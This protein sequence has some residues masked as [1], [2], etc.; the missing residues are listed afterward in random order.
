MPKSQ[1]HLATPKYRV[2]HKMHLISKTFIS[3][4]TAHQW[5]LP[6]ITQNKLQVDLKKKAYKQ[7]LNVKRFKTFRRKYR[8]IFV[9][10]PGRGF[11]ISYKYKPQT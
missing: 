3:N 11:E 8:R 9:Q 4:V 1:G 5:P 2:S 6:H 7:T 10:I